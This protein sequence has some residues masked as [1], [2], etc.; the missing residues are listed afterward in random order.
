[1]S[2]KVSTSLEIWSRLGGESQVEE[3]DE[4]TSPDPP[5]M[6]EQE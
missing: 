1:M 4:A 2:L 5:F 3:I 6:P